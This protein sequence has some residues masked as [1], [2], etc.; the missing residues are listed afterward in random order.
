MLA[1]NASLNEVTP[2]PTFPLGKGEGGAVPTVPMISSR[3]SKDG[4]KQR[5]IATIRAGK[6]LFAIDGNE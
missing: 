1:I 3:G 4:K 2:I 5:S 6:K